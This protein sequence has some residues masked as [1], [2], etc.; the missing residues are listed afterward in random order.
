MREVVELH[1]NAAANAFAL[2]RGTAAAKPK[3]AAEREMFAFYNTP[4]LPI[5]QIDA[6][7]DK[8]DY[9]KHYGS[10]SQTE[11]IPRF[12]VTPN[13]NVSGNVDS[14]R[15]SIKHHFNLNASNTA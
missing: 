12:K 1:M 2:N 13:P 4:V 11:R 14:V 8:V 9:T 3:L 15:A 7:R 5:K 6:I 10:F